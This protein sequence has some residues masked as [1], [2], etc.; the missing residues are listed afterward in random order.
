M[1]YPVKQKGG[2][3][4]IYINRKWAPYIIEFPKINFVSVD[5]EVMWI[6]LDPPNHRKLLIGTVYRPPD[7]KASSDHLDNSLLSF[8]EIELS[9]EVVIV[10]DFNIDYKK[11]S[12]PECKHLKEFEC[13]HQLKQYIK[14][15][16]CITNK[17][18]STI[19]LIFSNMNHIA[20]VGALKNQI[21]V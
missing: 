9:A 15:P 19:D 16:T 10:G 17:L 5:L 3:I 6:L 20:E 8:G 7:G 21:S 11:N 14:N 18:T 13:N 2:G 12:S 4:L 1:K